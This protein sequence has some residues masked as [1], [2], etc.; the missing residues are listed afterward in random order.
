V[1]V[2]AAKIDLKCVAE[3]KGVYFYRDHLPLLGEK[4]SHKPNLTQIAK[5]KYQQNDILNDDKS[6]I[7]PQTVEQSQHLVVLP[8]STS[9]G[10][11]TATNQTYSFKLCDKVNI[12][13][14]FEILQTLQV[15]HG[16]W[17][18]AM[19]EVKLS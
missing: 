10:F 4:T 11:Y 17:C 13:L 1:F 14:D 8:A 16:G 19:F 9:N 6:L 12:D 7:L 5:I 2:L 3:S 18:D 15:G